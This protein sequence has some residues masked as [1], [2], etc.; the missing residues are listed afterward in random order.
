MGWRSVSCLTS[1]RGEWWW[2][3]ADRDGSNVTWGSEGRPHLEEDTSA[4][5][6]L[7]ALWGKGNMCSQGPVWPEQC[8]RAC[9]EDEI[10]EQRAE[11][12]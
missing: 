8:K 11:W 3:E 7:E 6:H 2:H 1:S 10:R 9:A 4:G 12:V 5:V